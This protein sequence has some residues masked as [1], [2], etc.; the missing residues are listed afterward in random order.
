MVFSFSKAMC[1]DLALAL[2]ES[3]TFTNGQE[4]GEI[5]KFLKQKL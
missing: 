2:D 1:E 4:K 3:L 5:K